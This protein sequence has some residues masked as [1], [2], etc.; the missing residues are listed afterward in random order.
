[1]LKIPPKPKHSLLE[2]VK[3]NNPINGAKVK[4]EIVG[5]YV[6]D[7]VPSYIVGLSQD[8]PFRE[9]SYGECRSLFLGRSGYEFPEEG[10][11]SN[12]TPI[13]V[14]WETELKS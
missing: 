5:V 8:S 9:R 13:W 10:V 3:V 2:T 12:D 4:G 7:W 6:G 14:F 1:M 11:V